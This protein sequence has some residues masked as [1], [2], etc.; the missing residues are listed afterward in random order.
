MDAIDEKIIAE[1][2]RNARLS[3]S[4][5]AGRVLL[6]RNAVRQRIDGWSGTATSLATPS[7]V[8]ART[9][10]MSSRRSS[11]STARTA[12]AEATSWPHS[13]AFR[14]SSSVRSSA[15]TTTSWCAWR[16]P[17]LE[18]A[19][20]V[21]EN[22]AQMPGVRDTVTALTLSSIVNRPRRNGVPRHRGEQRRHRHFPVQ[23]TVIIKTTTST[24]VAKV[25]STPRRSPWRCGE[26]DR[27][28]AHR[29]GGLAGQVLLLGGDLRR[30]AA[31]RSGVDHSAVEAVG[32]DLGVDPASGDQPGLDPELAGH[33]LVGLAQAFDVGRFGRHE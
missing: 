14:R 8:R 26:K 7:S 6:S 3:H 24:P 5:L 31:R 16:R 15:A 32:A 9:P 17:R 18:R 30:R 10:A 22:I 29:P 25:S 1:L 2:T 20:V 27:R 13:R 12:C 33:D 21:W 11:S 23:S 19:R 28:R 4:E